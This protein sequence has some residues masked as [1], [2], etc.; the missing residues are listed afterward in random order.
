MHLKFEFPDE[1]SAEKAVSDAGFCLGQMQRRDPR[2]LMYEYDYVAKWRNLTSK[3]KSQLHGTLQRRA[4]GGPVV[5]WL[6]SACPAE[7]RH[8]LA[9]ATDNADREGN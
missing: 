1:A 4:R 7:A 2:G 3:E 5:V 6:R 8:S 9:R